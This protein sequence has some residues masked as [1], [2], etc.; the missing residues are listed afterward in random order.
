MLVRLPEIAD[1]EWRMTFPGF[2]ELTGVVRR[3]VVDH[4][5]FEIAARLQTQ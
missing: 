2:N 1:G 5:P 4:H 3:T